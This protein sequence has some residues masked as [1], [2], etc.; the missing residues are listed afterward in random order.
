MSHKQIKVEDMTLK[1]IWSSYNF[2]SAVFVISWFNSI[3]N[4]DGNV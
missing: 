3:K 4:L 2:I 1:R